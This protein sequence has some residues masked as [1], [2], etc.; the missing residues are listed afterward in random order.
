M[1]AF[2]AEKFKLV[3]KRKPRYGDLP[4]M[5]EPLDD[6]RGPGSDNV[7]PGKQ[8]SARVARITKDG[9]EYVAE[10]DM[11]SIP[12]GVSYDPT[13]EDIPETDGDMPAPDGFPDRRL[14]VLGADTR[15]QASSSTW[16]NWRL[17][18]LDYGNIGRCSGAIIGPNK[19][20][21]AAHCVYST[22]S[23]SWTVP[24]RVAPGRSGS[25]NPWGQ[26]DVKH[27]TVYTAWQTGG[28]W[29][30]DIAVLTIEGSGSTVNM[31]IG[32][33]MGYFGMTTHPCS[34]DNESQSRI[35]G[36][37][38]DKPDGTLWNTGVCDDW[39]Y[40]CGSMKVYHQCDTA[41]GMSGSAIRDGSNH[42]IGVHAYGGSW[43]SGTAMN[44]FHLA[45]VQSW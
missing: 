19:V 35:T 32:S 39:Y 38:G 26:W 4:D 31:D 22:S 41:G 15:F 12:E 43:N 25:L 13:K 18:E 36:Y 29:E 9:L 40:S 5:E 3:A 20:L 16:P 44:S 24:N 37:P 6:G 45:N 42:I 2:K 30:Y 33:Y 7:N 21:T 10:Y 1:N 34:S 17:T 28:G 8:R 27:A 23:G 14:S 11:D